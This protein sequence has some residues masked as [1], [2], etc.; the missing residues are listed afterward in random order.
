MSP[1]TVKS[2]RSLKNSGITQ[3]SLNKNIKPS[4]SAED[5][6]KVTELNKAIV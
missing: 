3:D 2:V 5:M 1:L 6:P 4:W